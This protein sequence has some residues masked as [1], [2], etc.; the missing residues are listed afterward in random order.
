MAFIVKD[1][2]P[3]YGGECYFVGTRKMRDPNGRE[4]EAA[5][6]G[7]IE[8]AV[9]F[10]TRS[11]AQDRAA[12]LNKIANKKQFVVEEYS[13]YS[14]KYGQRKTNGFAGFGSLPQPSQ[15]HGGFVWEDEG[16]YNGF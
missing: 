2:N 9:R 16:G 3:Q 15:A 11:S 1:T 4:C 14:Q 12:M 10:S 5:D 6:F 8:N 7:G 13:V